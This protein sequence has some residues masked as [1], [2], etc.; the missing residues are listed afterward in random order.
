MTLKEKGAPPAAPAPTGLLRHRLAILLAAGIGLGVAMV[1]L[2]VTPPEQ[3]RLAPPC[4]FHRFTGLHCPGCGAT[5]A[6]HA[7]MHLRLGEAVQK[8]ALFIIALPF[9]ALWSATNLTRWARG[10]P[11]REP[12]ALTRPRILVAILLAILA[13]AIL[14][15]LPWPPF[16]LLAPH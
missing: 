5:R 9:V 12:S 1:V 13:F 11:V 16:N 3:N 8:N 2:Y 10:E 7:L 6:V 14:R 15:N 4:L